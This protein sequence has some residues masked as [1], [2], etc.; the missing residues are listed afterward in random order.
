MHYQEAKK[1][2]FIVLALGGKRRARIVQSTVSKQ[3]GVSQQTASRLL[4]NLEEEGYIFRMVKG[5]GEFVE[6]TQKGLSTLEVLYGMLSKLMSEERGILVLEGKVVSGLGEGQYYMK[7]PY[8][9][10]RV[11]E[12]LNFV[13][14]PGTLNVQLEGESTLKR[15]ALTKESGLRIEGFRNEERFYGGATLFKAKINGFEKAGIIIP[16]RTSHPKDVIEIVAPIYLRGELGLKDGD[17]VVLEVKLEGGG[18]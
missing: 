2:V 17:R 12:L 6:L 14:Y 10:N 16:D 1:I 11:K 13:P 7:I 3:L 18:E 5:R 15:L 4:K 8:Y 9:R